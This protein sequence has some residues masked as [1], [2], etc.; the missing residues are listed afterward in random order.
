[1]KLVFDCRL[2]LDT[3]RS[4]H[5][6]RRIVKQ[7]TADVDMHLEVWPSHLVAIAHAQER[8]QILIY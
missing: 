7:Y 6:M 3:S 5:L 4:G 8:Q 1:M 2:S